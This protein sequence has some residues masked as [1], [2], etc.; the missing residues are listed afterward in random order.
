MTNKNIQEEIKKVEKE[1]NIGIDY[2][3]GNRV[4]RGIN[5]LFKLKQ[6]WKQTKYIKLIV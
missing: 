2:A 4:W 3:N 1:I 6:K 5:K